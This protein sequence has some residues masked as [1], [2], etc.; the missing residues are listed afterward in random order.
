V[1]RHIRQTYTLSLIQV[2]GVNQPTSL[3]IAGFDV[4]WFVKAV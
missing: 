4:S 3:L 2:N 1:W